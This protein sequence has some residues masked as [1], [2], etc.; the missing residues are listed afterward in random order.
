VAADMGTAEKIKKKLYIHTDIYYFT[1]F[2]EDVHEAL[3]SCLEAS[4]VSPRKKI[5]QTHY[6]DSY[7]DSI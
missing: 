1:I 6:A 4:F 7:F 3:Y 2:K 5:A